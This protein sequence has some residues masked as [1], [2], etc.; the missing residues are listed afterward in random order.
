M[1]GKPNYTHI[2]WDWN[3]TLLDDADY[4]IAT[5]NK[6]LR[7]R[8]MPLLTRER[9]WQ[10]FRFPII[11]YYKDLGFDFDKEPYE[12]LAEEY[13]ANYAANNR[14]LPLRK[15]VKEVLS[16]F[17]SKN[18]PQIILSASERIVLT[19]ALEM[20][21]IDKYFSDVLC[22]DNCLAEGKIAYG[23]KFADSLPNDSKILLVGDTEHDLETADAIGADCVLVRGGHT[24]DEKLESLPAK[25]VVSSLHE[26]YPI[27]FGEEKKKKVSSSP[28]G[29]AERRSFD[30]EEA[31]PKT[32]AVRYKAFYDDLKNTNKTEDW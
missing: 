4:C 6:S 16:V 18:I 1:R 21:G 26:L 22:T 15:E 5:V 9:Y 10:I 20:Y 12:L 28:V 32:F 7:K 24:S 2:F 17:R 13:T 8:S 19:D 14:D 23:K 27:V 30:L 25:A 31:E 3:G 29:A 11:E